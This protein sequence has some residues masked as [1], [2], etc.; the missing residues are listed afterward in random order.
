[1]TRRQ[2]YRFAGWFGAANAGLY[3][4]VSL[5]YLPAWSWPDSVLA[6]LYVPLTMI[7]HAGVLA[8]ALP[9]LVLAPLIA[10]WPARRVVMTL[11][12]LMAAV[13]LVLLVQDT[14][15]YVERRF[16]LSL[17]TAA[18][19]STATWV[20]TGIVLLIALVFEALLAGAIGRWVQ[21]PARGRR[22][23]GPLLGAVIAGSWLA[24]QGIHI[25]ADAVAFA[26]VTRFTQ[27]LPLYYPIHAKRKLAKLGWL[28]EDRVLQARLLREAGEGGAGITGDIRYPLAPLQCRVPAGSGGAAPP[29]VLWILIDALR[30]DAIDTEAMPAVAAFR[31]AGESFANHWS[32]GN[33][34]RMGLFSMFYGL[35]STYW[36][37]FYD[38]QRPPVLMDEFRRQ[39]YELVT[40]SAVGYRSPTLIDRTVFAGVAGLEPE[41]KGS[42]AEKNRKVTRD[43]QAWLAAREG[44]QPFLAFL[45]YD[46]PFEG[47]DAGDGLPVDATPTRY[48][49]NA[50]AE[51][52]WTAYRRG[53][54]LVDGEVAKVLAD[55][56]AAGL[57][58]DT[59][60]IVA[61]DHG[62]EFD[63]LGLGYYGHASNFGQYQ[64]RA[65][66]LMDWPGRESHV[67]THRTAHQDLP[68]TLLEGLFG[69]T[70]PP[71]D[72]SSGHN[73]YAGESWE[74]IIAGSYHAHAIVEPGRVTVS[75]PGGF[76]EVLGPDYRSADTRL[77][78]RLIEAAMAEMRRFHQ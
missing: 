24:S 3:L 36:Q 26:P 46:P 13:G 68:A 38:L 16:H 65:T 17:F 72:Y 35:P 69:C 7:G 25:W 31:E 42:G 32:G 5:R 62:Y 18:L 60:V 8:I 57:R 76:A 28:D 74:W 15:L 39:G 63:D 4:L 59:L 75:E 64:L 11:A 41:A 48:P 20:L 19:F 14:N 53:L 23:R 1:M 33:S 55:L 56:D 12:A 73:L 50:E 6:S 67:Y 78:A 52:R 61:S 70:N 47:E 29:N 54:R 21:Q 71:A 37:S 58:E 43:W 44:E 34:S 66:L 10:A 51:A 77:D 27:V 9:L 49:G 40:S 30:P 45:Y 22:W 2:L